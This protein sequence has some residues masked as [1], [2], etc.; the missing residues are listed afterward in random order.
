MMRTTRRRFLEQMGWLT[1]AAAATTS[2]KASHVMQLATAPVMDTRALARFV[3]PLPI[4]ALAKPA[5]LR[6]RPGDPAS[7]IPWYRIV[8]QQFQAKVHRDVP[9][10]TFWGYDAS[11]P[12]PTIEVRQGK[13]ILVE[14]AN[15][16]PHQHFLP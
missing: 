1:A 16:P 4:P 11:C 10:T 8:M 3:D 14:W 2:A 6:P 9:P 5:G 12:G 15:Q 13:P 7:Q